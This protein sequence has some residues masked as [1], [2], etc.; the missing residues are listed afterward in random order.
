M[1]RTIGAQLVDLII[2]AQAQQHFIALDDMNFSDESRKAIIPKLPACAKELRDLCRLLNENDSQA[3]LD[4]LTLAAEKTDFYLKLKKGEAKNLAYQYRQAIALKLK[5]ET[6][7]ALVLH[8]CVISI[9]MSKT[10]SMIHAP[11]RAI[12]LL[13]SFLMK[14]GYI[15][16]EA[17]MIL[18]EFQSDVIKSM[19][20]AEL[21]EK[22]ELSKKL[23]L[24]L[25][26]VRS[27]P[28][29]I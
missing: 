27:M 8:L 19:K 21:L 22:S 9:F 10:H 14:R 20:T 15:H 6:D 17:F 29:N 26:V 4:V 28:E 2:K 11:G 24:Q 1:I 7:P 12:P 13:L 16:E 5:E 3:L 18:K 23:T 25:S